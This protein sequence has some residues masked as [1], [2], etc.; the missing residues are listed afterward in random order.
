V[1]F[2]FYDDYK[3]LSR[4][5]IFLS[6]QVDGLHLDLFDKVTGVAALLQLKPDEFA[7]QV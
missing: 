1:L 2:S 4:G 7:K 6:V 5:E 3:C